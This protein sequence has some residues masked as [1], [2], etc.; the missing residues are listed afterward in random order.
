MIEKLNARRTYKVIG[1]L[2]TPVTGNKLEKS[3]IDELLSASANA[4]FHYAC[5]RIHKTELSSS[6]PWRVHKLQAGDCNKLKDFLIASGDVTKVTNML[7]AAEFLFQVTWLPDEDT[8]IDRDAGKEEP[9]FV[10]TLRNMEHIAAASAFTQS[11]LLAG[12]EQGFMTYW[13]SGGALKSADTFNYLKISLNELLLGA[14]FF[15]PKD[16]EHAEIKSGAMKEAR[17]TIDDWSKW[18]DIS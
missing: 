17:G 7:A 2:E 16:V 9:A 4:P 3:A 13:S 5:D 8:I 6:V 18:C 11:L 10:G 1:D 14:I 12:E 15:F